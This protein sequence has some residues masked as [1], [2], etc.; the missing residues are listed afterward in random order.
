MNPNKKGKIT[1]QVIS[2]QILYV[3]WPVSVSVSFETTPML[4]DGV[5]QRKGQTT[6][7]KHKLKCLVY[8]FISRVFEGYQASFRIQAK[9]SYKNCT[10]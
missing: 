1:T 7:A 5:A 3:L 2:K 10:L 6:M 8:V 4:D 9:K